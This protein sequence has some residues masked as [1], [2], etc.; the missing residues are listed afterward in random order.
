MD[1]SLSAT[2]TG[3]WSK[4]SREMNREEF[5]NYKFHITLSGDQVAD[6]MAAG[7]MVVEVGKNSDQKLAQRLPAVLESIREQ[8]DDPRN[9]YGYRR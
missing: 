4:L 6:L 1:T 9:S 7:V 2:N 5:L 3:V 8:L